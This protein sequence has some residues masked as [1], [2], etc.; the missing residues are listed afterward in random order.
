MAAF[1]SQ[2][3]TECFKLVQDGYAYLDIRTPQEFASAHY[4]GAINIPAFSL[5]GPTPLQAEFLEKV[6]AAFPAKDTKM[7]VACASGRRSKVAMAWMVEQ[8]YA[9]AVENATGWGGWMEANL[10]AES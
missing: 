1:T 6:A 9:N 4:P 7:V 3:P 5:P 10:P 8:G 2:T